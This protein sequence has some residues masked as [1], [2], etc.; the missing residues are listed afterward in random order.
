M[1]TEE[2][3]R[4][5]WTKLEWMLKFHAPRAYWLIPTADDYVVSLPAPRAEDLPL[6]TASLQYELREGEP[7]AIAQVYAT[8]VE[9]GSF[10]KIAA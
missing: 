10:Q 7:Y 2:K 4:T 8:N 1:R 5:A 3:F 9:K 6:G